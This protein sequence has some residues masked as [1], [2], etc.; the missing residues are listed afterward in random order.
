MWYDGA[1]LPSRSDIYNHFDK[2]TVKGE[3]CEKALEECATVEEVIQLYT[4]FYTPHWQGHSMWA[5]RQGNSVI[6]E[7]GEKDVVFLPKDQGYQVMTNY[8]LSDSTNQRWSSCHRFKAITEILNNQEDL[9]VGLMTLALNAS[10]KE[11]LTPT[12]YSN[13]YDLKKGDI[14][15]YHFHYYGE[16]VRFNLAEELE[17]GDQY[18]ELPSLFCRIKTK[19]PSPD[20]L[21]NGPDVCFNWS[22]GAA[23]YEVHYSEDPGFNTFNIEKVSN[24]IPDDVQ[25]LSYAPVG[26]ILII[27]W[28]IR[29]RRRQCLLFLSLLLL[30]GS[31]SSCTKLFISPQ[32]PESMEF[33]ACVKNL[34]PG[35]TY[36]WKIIS[37]EDNR[38]SS[39]SIAQTF[40]TS[41]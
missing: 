14:Y 7:Y 40:R 28:S 2:P 33:S 41:D 31:C 23:D 24:P 21:V 35:R 16:Y 3:L 36:H 4:E 38:M 17:K 29:K 12:L 13:I 25:R 26:I 37:L 8:Y 32:W 30:L 1:S 6:I 10:H 19:S 39:E 11:G 18:L 34:N 20:Q 9:S 15:I 27:V 22:G 5:D